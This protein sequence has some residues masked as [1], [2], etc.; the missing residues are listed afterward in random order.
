MAVL[1]SV[2]TVPDIQPVLQAGGL[3]MFGTRYIGIYEKHVNPTIEFPEIFLSCRVARLGVSGGAY[4][5]STPVE[6]LFL[7]VFRHSNRSGER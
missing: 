5:H 7:Q 3:G 1:A 2:T 4:D 6:A